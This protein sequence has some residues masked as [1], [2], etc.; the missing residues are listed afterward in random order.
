MEDTIRLQSKDG[1]EFEIS[2]KAAS[3]SDYLK[4]AMNEFLDDTPVS[5]QDIDEKT[6]EKV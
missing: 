2:K 6:T 5:L 3:L 1:K 4:A